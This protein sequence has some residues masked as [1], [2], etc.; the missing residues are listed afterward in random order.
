MERAADFL[1]GGLVVAAGYEVAAT[2]WF[3]GAVL[4]AFAAL[5]FILGVLNRTPRIVIDGDVADDLP[6]HRTL[7]DVD[8]RWP[9]D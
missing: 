5:V 3:W 7:T 6:A 8:L 2:E 1:T 4:A 9:D